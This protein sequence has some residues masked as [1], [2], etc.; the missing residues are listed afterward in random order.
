MSEIQSNYPRAKV[1]ASSEKADL[2]AVQD[3]ATTGIIVITILT[4]TLLAHNLGPKLGIATRTH[5]SAYGM[6]IFV[7]IG[8]AFFYFLNLFRWTTRAHYAVC[9]LRGYQPRISSRLAGVGSSASVF[10]LGIPTWFAFDFLITHSDPGSSDRPSFSWS[11]AGLLFIVPYV[12]SMILL[13]AQF[14]PIWSES[15]SNTIYIARHVILAFS[16]WAGCR[17]VT[18]TNTNLF[19]L[20]KHVRSQ[21]SPADQEPEVTPES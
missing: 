9:L 20:A 13:V 2:V 12:L 3:S 17:M 8:C 14:L 18:Q 19:R 16:V 7:I 15:A 10:M 5:M 6:M 21:S 4:G 1:V 11:F